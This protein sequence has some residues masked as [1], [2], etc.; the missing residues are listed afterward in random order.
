MLENSSIIAWLR[1]KKTETGKPI[2]LHDGFFMFDIF[3]D[4]SQK[5]AIQKPAQVRATTTQLFKVF[6]GMQRYGLEAIYT[7]PTVADANE[8]SKSKI[9]RLI[10]QNPDLKT[11]VQEM[12]TMG[13]KKVGKNILYIR[14]TWTEKAAMM[15]PSDWNLYDEVDASNQE[16]IEAYS[17]R[18]QH[19]KHKWEHYFSHPSTVGIGVNKVFEKSDQKHWFITCG[20]C[21]KQQILEWPDSIDIERACF[22]CKSCREPL[23]DEDR[24]VGEWVKKHNNRDIS[25]YQISLL[26]APW[27]TAKEII[28]YNIDKSPEQFTTKILGLPYVGAGN[29]VT[30][31]V[32]QK[33]ITFDYP[34]LKDR[35]IIGLDTGGNKWYVVGTRQGLFYYGKDNAYGEVERLL[36]MFDNSVVIVDGN[37]DPTATEALFEKYRGRVFKCFF[38]AD[39]KTQEMVTFGK[40][41]DAGIVWADRNRLIQRVVD[42]Y[43]DGLIRLFAQESETDWYDYFLHW[44]NMYREED[45]NALGVPVK[46]W[47]RVG[48]DH[49][50]L[51][52]AY[53]RAGVDKFGQGMAKVVRVNKK[54]HLGVPS[55]HLMPDGKVKAPDI[56][57]I[58]KFKK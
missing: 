39:R 57:K 15:F 7:L 54:P 41:S 49:W 2:D 36:K 35:I 31:D 34:D 18:L 12:D 20:R 48:D 8:M 29:K 44:N 9:N 50:G 43:T 19:S 4:F 40:D 24:R 47:K 1:N 5:L 32:L 6:W 11:M 58:W 3:R 56:H 14:G 46:R 37:G 27:I 25:G 23:A 38:N 13:Q 28:G 42:E 55:M 33:N 16:V 10:A 21:S 30:W 26:M 53:W 45:E 52:T 17:T 51:A 22:I